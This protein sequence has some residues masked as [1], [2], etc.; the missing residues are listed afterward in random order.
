IP[1]LHEVTRISMSTMR[2]SLAHFDQD[3]LITQDRLRVNVQADFYVRVIPQK[4]AVAAAARTLGRKTMSVD[5]M[6]Q[7]FEARFNDALRTAAAEQPMEALHESRGA[8]SK[9]VRELAS[10]GL[11]ASGL[12]IDSVSFSKL[13]Q[14]SREYFN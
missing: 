6:R 9:R 4:Q 2:M 13:D 14:A 7:L 11:E 12:E 8:F 3:A 10:M 5:E 1:V